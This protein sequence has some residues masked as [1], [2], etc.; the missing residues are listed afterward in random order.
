MN[1]DGGLV[2]LRMGRDG[3]LRKKVNGDIP[4]FPRYH[5]SIGNPILVSAI[6]RKVG[7]HEMKPK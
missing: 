4:K 5:G 3:I 6:K 2:G 7:S 1:L